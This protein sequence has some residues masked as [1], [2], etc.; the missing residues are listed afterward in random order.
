[1]VKGLFIVAG[2]DWLMK[3]ND[4]KP[5]TD[6]GVVLFKSAWRKEWPFKD[7]HYMKTRGRWLGVGVV[8]MLFDV[9]ERVNE[10]KN[11]KRTS[12]Q[13][14]ALKL[15]QT[16][17]KSVV[18]N[19]LTDLQ[20]GDVMLTGK[21]G[22]ITPIENKEQNLEAFKDEEESYSEQT[23]KLSFAY[24]AL[25]GD[26]SDA[27]TP[28]GTTQIAVAQGTSVFAFKKENLSLF[29]QEFFNDLVLPEL[30]KDMT[31]EHMMRFIGSTQEIQKL[32]QA[33]AEVHA[34]N[35]V[36]GELLKGKLVTKMDFDGAKQKAITTYQKLG[37]NRF[38]KIKENFYQ[39]AEFEFDFLITPE[40][41]DPAKMATNIQAVISEVAQNPN[42]LTDPR[43]KLLFFKLCD[44][45][46]VSQAEI[47]LA[48]QQATEMQQQGQIG[49][50]GKP[51]Q[52]QPQQQNQQ[53][54]GGFNANS[55]LR[56]TGRGQPSIPQ[57]PQ[58]TK[59]I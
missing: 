8:E 57:L 28:L 7:F 50:D 36:K 37:G 48:D 38:L 21:E 51:V 40:Q 23:D 12:M 6:M 24:E 44:Q 59:G 55:L 18:R 14:G 30:M 56:L 9:Q 3:N 13:I 25:R 29:L 58:L 4:G 53:A 22:G 43:L 31:P 2:A 16:P 26:T 46:G 17:D 49:P 27:S 42:I 54:A 34:N 11:Q 1:M 45:L 35:Y 5:I 33:A 19:V 32:D 10:L 15:F 20:N 39:D 41:A 47:E 52:Q